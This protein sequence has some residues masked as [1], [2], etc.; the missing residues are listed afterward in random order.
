MATN[1]EILAP[2]WLTLPNIPGTHSTTAPKG[3][4][5]ISGATLIFHDG[6]SWKVITS[7]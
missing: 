7:A 1:E 4:I 6:T 5:A 2:K 3:S